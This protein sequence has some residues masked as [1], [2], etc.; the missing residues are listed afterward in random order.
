MLEYNVADYMNKPEVRSLL[1]ISSKLGVWEPCNYKIY[2]S[3][4]YQKEGSI[5]LYPLLKANG[6]RILFFSG[7]T[8]LVIP[9]FGTERWI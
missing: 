1:H 8:D 2:E 9:L 3:W 7:D 6:I 4:K 5:F